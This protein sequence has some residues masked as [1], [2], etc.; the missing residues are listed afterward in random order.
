MLTKEKLHHY[1]AFECPI[2]EIAAVSD[3]HCL[4]TDSPRTCTQRYQLLLHRF[5]WRCVLF[6]PLSPSRVLFLFLRF[7]FSH[8]LSLSLCEFLFYYTWFPSGWGL[9]SFCPS[10]ARSL[11]TFI[12]FSLSNIFYRL[13]FPYAI[14]FCL[15]IYHFHDS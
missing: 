9:F 11:S 4:A 15:H 8:S 13:S 14:T 6:T 1:L 2:R 5:T 7:S 10:L 3:R 12:L